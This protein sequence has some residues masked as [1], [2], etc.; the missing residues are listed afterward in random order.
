VNSQNSID[1]VVVHD[2]TPHHDSRGNLVEIFRESWNLGDRPV[3]FNAVTSAVGVL[4]GVHVHVRHVDHLVLVSGRMIFGLH[5]LRPWSPT[6][7]RSRQ[8]ELDTTTPRAVVIP[9]GVA[10]GFYF[11]EPSLLVYG[12]STYWNP[13]DEIACR[14]DAPELHLSWPTRAPILSEQDTVA[15]GYAAFNDRFLQRWVDVHGALPDRGTV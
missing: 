12:A 7:R 15:G 14:W 10:H 2:L 5:D 8:L 13:D 6:A 3:Q 11:A 9:V 4:R 1:G